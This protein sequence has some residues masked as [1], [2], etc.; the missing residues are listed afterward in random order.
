MFTETNPPLPGAADGPDPPPITTASVD[1]R[2]RLS[3]SSTLLSLAEPIKSGSH[4]TRRWRKLDSNPRSPESGTDFSNLLIKWQRVR[5]TLYEV[6]IAAPTKSLILRRFNSETAPM[7]PASPGHCIKKLLEIKTAPS[8][9]PARMS[10]RCTEKRRD[11]VR[12][13]GCSETL[14]LDNDPTSPSMH[15]VS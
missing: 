1:V 11:T 13:R 8:S 5:P 12:L 10:W 15:K 7:R 2:Q 3:R 9:V 6:L 14:S 4:R